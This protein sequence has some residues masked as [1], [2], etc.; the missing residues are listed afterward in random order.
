[1]PNRRQDLAELPL[2][3]AFDEAFKIGGVGMVVC[4]R[5]ATGTLRTGMKVKAERNPELAAEKQG[6]QVGSITGPDFSMKIPSNYWIDP[7]QSHLIEEAKPGMI[8][9]FNLKY[10]LRSGFQHQSKHLLISD[11]TD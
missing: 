1:M 11:P 5:I 2:R 8:V 9:G 7:V 6:K 10:A 3:I 4:G